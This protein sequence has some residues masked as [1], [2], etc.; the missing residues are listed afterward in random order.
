LRRIAHGFL[1]IALLVAIA[2]LL[3]LLLPMVVLSERWEIH[4][5]GHSKCSNCGNEIGMTEI[6]RAKREAGMRSSRIVDNILRRGSIPRVVV[7]WNVVCP[8]C[9]QEF[10]YRTDAPQRR[11][12]PK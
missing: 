8:A 3:P 9:G 11:L 5:L 1:L 12:V 10:A 2:V 7:A 6:R 4:K